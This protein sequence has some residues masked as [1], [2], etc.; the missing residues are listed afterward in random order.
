[1][2]NVVIWEEDALAFFM[3]LASVRAVV[4]ASPRGQGSK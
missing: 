4:I 3:S 2:E 1:M